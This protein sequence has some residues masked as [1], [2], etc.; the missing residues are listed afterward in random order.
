[1]VSTP[2]TSSG[3]LATPSETSFSPIFFE[4]ALSAPQVTVASPD[5]STPEGDWTTRGWHVLQFDLAAE[6]AKTTAA[7]KVNDMAELVRQ[8]G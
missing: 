7:L 6:E 1:M 3:L 2:F 4:A 8:I 5:A